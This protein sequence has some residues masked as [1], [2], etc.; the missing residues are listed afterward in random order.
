[1]DILK[2]I[3]KKAKKFTFKKKTFN[4]KK[5]ARDMTQEQL[6]G[7]D[8]S[9]LDQIIPIITDEHRAILQQPGGI[10][11]IPDELL[12]LKEESVPT[13]APVPVPVPSPV[14]ENFEGPEDTIDITDPSGMR[15]LSHEAQIIKFI[16][17][18]ELGRE[19]FLSE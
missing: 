1:M 7:L 8:R 18:K 12:A 4:L 3:F 16:N 5:I 13:L 6:L 15:G 17:E 14:Q 9:V 10:I 2:R 19:V 11:S